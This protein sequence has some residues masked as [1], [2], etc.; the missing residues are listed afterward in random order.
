MGGTTSE[1]LTFLT[2]HQLTLAPASENDEIAVTALNIYYSDQSRQSRTRVNLNKHPINL[3]YIGKLQ[4]LT[5]SH[6]IQGGSGNWQRTKYNKQNKQTL[7]D[8]IPSEFKTT[9]HSKRTLPFLPCISTV[10]HQDTLETNS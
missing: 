7:S 8:E 1:Q 3:N 9:K 6:I 4:A 10:N 2:C 5:T